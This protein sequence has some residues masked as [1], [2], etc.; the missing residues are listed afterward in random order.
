GT[1]TSGAPP[2]T[3]A[4]TPDRNPGPRH[5]PVALL[6]GVT[7]DALQGV[8]AADAHVE[9]VGAELLDRLR[10]AVSHLALSGQFMGAPLPLISLFRVAPQE[11]EIQGCEDQRPCRDQPGTEHQ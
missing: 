5:L 11:V 8:D 9:L 2:T 1:G 7:G 3:P 10:V 6:C 4:P